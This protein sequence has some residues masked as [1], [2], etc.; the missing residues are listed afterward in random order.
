MCKIRPTLASYI[1]YLPVFVVV[2]LFFKFFFNLHRLRHASRHP[3][4]GV[5]PVPVPVSN[6]HHAR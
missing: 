1:S 4:F 2:V 5:R 6:F 3:I